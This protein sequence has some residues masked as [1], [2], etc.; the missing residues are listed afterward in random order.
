MLFSTL[1]YAATALAA[2]QNYTLRGSGGE[3]LRIYNGH[4]VTNSSEGF[5][6]KIQT[7]SG[8]LLRVLGDTYAQPL[9]FNVNDLGDLGVIGDPHRLG[10]NG[11]VLTGEG[12]VKQL[13][14]R[15]RKEW[16]A[17]DVR[18][19]KGAELVLIEVGY[20]P[21]CN[22]TRFFTVSATPVEDDEE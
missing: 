19:L 8:T 14:Y 6:F 9:R 16:Y 17:C 20:V 1:F 22:A 12:K 11:W 13:E 4:V 21:F 18:R 2:A 3:V 5:T 7:Q 10:Q 15:G